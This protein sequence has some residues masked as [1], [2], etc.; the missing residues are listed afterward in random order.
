[1]QAHY[2]SLVP[3]D[4]FL[5]PNLQSEIFSARHSDSQPKSF[6]DKPAIEKE[7]K[8]RALVVDDVADVTEMLSVLL[9]H[10]GYEVATA[11]SAAAAISSATNGQFDVII[12]DIGMPQMNGYELA[13]A[14]RELP[15]YETVPMVALTGYSKFDD[16][17]RSLDAGFNAHLT[18]PIEPRELLDLIEQL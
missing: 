6:E 11:S 14:V 4:Y 12:S 17:Q 5:L 7:R 18:K 16:R 1:M 8:R 2:P 3:A 15:G 13:R 9:T 10:A